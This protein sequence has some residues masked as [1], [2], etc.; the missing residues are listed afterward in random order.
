MRA[1]RIHEWLSEPKLDQV[2]KP[3]PGAGEIL[4]RIAGAGVCSSDVHVVYE[5]SPETMP[6]LDA[7]SLPLTLGHENGGWISLRRKR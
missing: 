1:F 7:W 6:H 2:E 5:W 4:I 3:E